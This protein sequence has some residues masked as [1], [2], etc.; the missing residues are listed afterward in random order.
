MKPRAERLVMYGARAEA[1]G[2]EWRWV[3]DQLVNAGAYWVVTPGS[4]H[5]HPRPVWGIWYDDELF[6]SIGSPKIKADAQAQ[7]AVTVHLG[8]VNDVVIVEGRTA[9]SAAD[10]HLLNAYTAKYDWNYTVDE[11]GPF[12]L[13][14]PAKGIA[15]RSAGWAGRDGFQ[16]TGR[17]A[18]PP[19]PH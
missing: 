12:T 9:G 2:L 6:L 11:Y 18:F 3:E 5:P 8:S 10:S 4:D 14:E 7:G 16:A 1:D 19:D 17:W 13:V 15:W